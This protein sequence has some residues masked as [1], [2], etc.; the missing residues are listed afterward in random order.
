MAEAVDVEA[1]SRRAH[2]RVTMTA[3][4]LAVACALP[5][6]NAGTD[7]PVSGTITVNGTAGALPAGGRFGGS[8]YDPATGAIAAG[9]FEFP[10]AT[11]QFD[12]PVGTVAATYALTQTNL[13]T[14]L[15]AVD[16][17]A[18]L[19]LASMRLEILSAQVVGPFPIPIPVG[20]DCVFEPIEFELDGTASASGLALADAA[21]TIPLIEPTACGGNGDAIND[22][23]AGGSNSI[24]LQIAGDFTPPSGT[25]DLVFADGFD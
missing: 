22:G 24:A 18:A 25:V 7:Y 23:I 19:T 14:G 3:A 15:V 21:F 13:S 9:A 4:A 11:I 1:V 2:R 5:A 20:N 10:N 16:G 8:S 17:V 6:A 12:S